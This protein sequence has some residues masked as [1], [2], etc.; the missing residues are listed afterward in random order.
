MYAVRMRVRAVLRH[1]AVEFERD[2]LASAKPFVG[3][4]V[5]LGRQ[6]EDVPLF[7]AEVKWSAVFGTYV[8]QA[9]DDQAED[10]YGDDAEPLVADYVF[11]GWREIRRVGL[12][13]CPPKKAS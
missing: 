9:E 1:V 12:S 5:G 8:C 2:V 11:A 7:L 3:L 4:A 13:L 10:A 6:G